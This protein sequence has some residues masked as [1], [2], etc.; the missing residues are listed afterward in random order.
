MIGGARRGASGGRDGRTEPQ[1]AAGRESRGFFVSSTRIV[2]QMPGD[3]DERPT[4]RKRHR[5]SRDADYRAVYA[6]RIKKAKGPLLVF[7]RANG[8]VEHRLGLAVGRRVG[9]AVARNRVKRLLREAFRLEQSALPRP[10]A[11]LSYDIIV[12]A[13]PHAPMPL[14]TYR[15]ALI[16]LVTRC[17]REH[18][19]RA[20]RAGEP[21]DGR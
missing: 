6:E 17:D 4:Y 13:R 2:P 12:S 20:S 11:D 10:C 9:N 16:E 19:K 7:V 8:L 14:A 5:L 15:S 18:H 1:Q 21:P 3:R